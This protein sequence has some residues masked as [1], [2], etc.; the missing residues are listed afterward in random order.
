MRLLLC[1]FVYPHARP[2]CCASRLHNVIS[3]HCACEASGLNECMSCSSLDDDTY[4]LAV[5]A[6]PRPLS[7]IIKKSFIVLRRSCCSHVCSTDEIGWQWQGRVWGKRR[8]KGRGG[9]VPA[10]GDLGQGLAHQ[11]LPETG[12]RS[13]SAA[14]HLDLL[15]GKHILSAVCAHTYG[16]KCQR[17]HFAFQVTVQSFR[18]ALCYEKSIRGYFF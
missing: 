15:P 10:D 17:Y 12:H 2:L 6:R 9:T 4:A 8:G 14:I 18:I 16:H 7:P 11:L 13:P 5:I 3:Y 1:V